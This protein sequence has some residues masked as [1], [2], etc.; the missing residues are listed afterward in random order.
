MRSNLN[1]SFISILSAR[2]NWCGHAQLGSRTCNVP[3]I[4][5]SP[6]HRRP[7]RR[8][9]QPTMVVVGRQRKPKN[10]AKKSDG[11]KNHA[12]APTVLKR[13]GMN[14]A[15]VL[16][17]QMQSFLGT[18]MMTR[19]AVVAALCKCIKEKDLYVTDNKKFFRCIEPL[20]NLL[21]VEGEFPLLQLH[22]LV[23]PH[24]IH[25][26]AAGKEYEERSNKMFQEYLDERGAIDSSIVSRQKDP[27]GLNSA[28]AQKELHARRR[29]I[30]L[31]VTL[32]P[33]LYDIC[34]GKRMLSRAQILKSIW[35]YIKE[36][37]LQD[38]NNGR[39]VTVDKHL[40]ESLGIVGKSTIDSFHLP[41]YIW[42]KC[43]QP[44]NPSS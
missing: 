43:W 32:D 21:G 34:G 27:R 30:H 10:S 40:G 35:T 3:T 18:D 37:K 28:K 15:M 36:N 1:P 23:S 8:D 2:P 33:T 20:S 29:G 12:A 5:D 14:T 7:A 25:P 26:T 13:T 4:I 42:K 16:S 22:A 39:I 41:R 9:A 17:P 38:P 19:P 11:G 6:L 24:L 31:E 44:P